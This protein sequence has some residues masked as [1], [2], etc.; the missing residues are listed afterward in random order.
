[1]LP[2]QMYTHVIELCQNGGGE[3]R[4]PASAADIWQGVLV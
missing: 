4:M 1:L 3:V 2:G